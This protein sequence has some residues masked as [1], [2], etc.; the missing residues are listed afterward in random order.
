[1]RVFDENTMIR[2]ND[3]R[4]LAKKI[5]YENKPGGRRYWVRDSTCGKADAFNLEL[6]EYQPFTLDTGEVIDWGWNCVEI[7][8]SSHNTSLPN[9]RNTIGG[10]GAYG[11]TFDRADIAVLL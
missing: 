9:D 3:V 6:Q 11:T 7:I 2:I 10:I 8:A 5:R 4:E 1:M